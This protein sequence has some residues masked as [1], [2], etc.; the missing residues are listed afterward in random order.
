MSVYFAQAGRYTKVGYS[1]D[2]IARVGSVTTNGARPADIPRGA[3]ARLL[4]WIP[5]DRRR[6]SEIHA[7]FSDRRV[8]AGGEWF[9]LEEDEIRD[10][11][12]SD[13][14]GI[15]V[16]R[17]AAMA[18]LAGSKYP[19]VTRADMAAAGIPVEA[20]SLEDALAKLGSFLSGAA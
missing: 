10:L 8:E 9:V 16:Q 1:A 19:G 17:M 11:I 4:G 14:S 3:D 13:P 15:D 5:G 20:T 12:W 7:R 18:V 6:E 2:P